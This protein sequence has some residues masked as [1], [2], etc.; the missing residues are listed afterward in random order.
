MSPAGSVLIVFGGLVYVFAMLALQIE[1]H[2]DARAIYHGFAW[3]G[4]VVFLLGVILTSY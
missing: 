3:V 2:P 4:S 1:R